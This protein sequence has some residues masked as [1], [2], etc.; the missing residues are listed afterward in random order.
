M[1]EEQ[2][3]LQ[4]AARSRR[5]RGGEWSGVGKVC[6]EQ[7]RRRSEEWRRRSEE[8]RRRSE[9]GRHSSGAG[10]LAQVRMRVRVKERMG[11]GLGENERGER[12]GLRDLGEK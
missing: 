6:K 10:G 9:H 4:A 11:G 7:L 12:I 8:W 5:Q 2:Q 3:R 1:R